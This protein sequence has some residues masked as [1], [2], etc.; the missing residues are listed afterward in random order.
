M[1]ELFLILSL[2]STHLFIRWTWLW[3]IVHWQG[4]VRCIKG[5]YMCQWGM[6]LHVIIW[7]CLGAKGIALHF[8]EV[9]CLYFPS[10]PVLSLDMFKLHVLSLHTRSGDYQMQ[11]V[12]VVNCEKNILVAYCYA[13]LIG[14]LF[15][16]SWVKDSLFLWHVH[17]IMLT[18]YVE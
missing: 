4:Y 8:S 5:F 15:F 13:S 12:V 3:V 6:F 1:F 2:C 17:H 14:S 9:T 16:G 18:S 11:W 7:P 10:F